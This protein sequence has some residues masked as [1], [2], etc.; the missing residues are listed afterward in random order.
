MADD[1]RKVF[2]YKENSNLVLSQRGRR[3][4]NEPT[5]EVESLWGKLQQGGVGRMGERER[6]W[7]GNDNEAAN[8]SGGGAAAA[9]KRQLDANGSKSDAGKKSKKGKY[10]CS[11]PTPTPP[12]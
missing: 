12:Q 5:G 11:T 7:R 2:G 6:E 9:P 8:P 3:Q 1:S 4:G 10:T